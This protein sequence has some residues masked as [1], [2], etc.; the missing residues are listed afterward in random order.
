MTR[1]T[2]ATTAF[3]L[4]VAASAPA[5]GQTIEIQ[6]DTTGAAIWTRPQGMSNTLSVTGSAVGYI[7]YLIT[8]VEAAALSIFVPVKGHPDPYIF[9][10]RDTFDPLAPFANLVAA[11]DDSGGGI[12]N[13]D[14]LI[15]ADVATLTVGEYTLVVSGFANGQDGSFT[16]FLDGAVVGWGLTTAEQLAE[17]QAIAAQSGRQTLRVM[18]GNIASALQEG[19]ATRALRFSTKGTEPVQDM[20]L[21][22]RLSN[23][24]GL[25]ASR[26][27][28]MPLLQV[29]ADWS[30]AP[31]LVMGV[32]LATARLSAAN[33]EA[34]LAGDQVL[35]Q[36]YLGWSAG[37]WHGRASVVLGRI[38]YDTLE[39]SG[40]TA[41]AKGKM[42]AATLDI[43]RDFRLADGAVVSPF[44]ALHMGQITLTETAGSLA[45]TGVASAVWFHEARLGA[46]YS[47]KL[48]EGTAKLSVSLDHFDTNA[49]IDLAS[50]SHDQT[51]WSGTVGFGYDTALGNGMV[52]NGSVKMGGIGSASRTAE[53]AVTFGWTF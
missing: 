36:P 41:S 12:S 37:D 2:F 33:T 11:D 29:G 16:V 10:Y 28:S 22:F 17:L 44:A 34:V 46:A 32:A 3:A 45:A 4:C 38:S 15:G 42:R 26:S 43:A 8:I 30:V 39:T 51:G 18:T 21:W 35:L 47:R 23:S 52:L 1:S 27:L 20:V 7:T 48:G 50:G 5:F 40:G 14:A 25:E 13:L 49:P 31:N 9:L 6:G 24:Q 53:A 19:E